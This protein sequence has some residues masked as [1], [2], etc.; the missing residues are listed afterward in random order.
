LS[1]YSLLIGTSVRVKST[2][3]E[4]YDLSVRAVN[5]RGTSSIGEDVRK[6]EETVTEKDKEKHLNR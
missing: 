6:G 2:L 3:T 1:P 4:W 5:N